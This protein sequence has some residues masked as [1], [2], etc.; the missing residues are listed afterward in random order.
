MVLAGC[1][2]ARLPSTIPPGDPS[3]PV[4]QEQ[5]VIGL[6]ASGDLAAAELIDADGE[7]PRLTLQRM[8]RAGSARELLVAPEATASAVAGDLRA[9]GRMAVPLLGAAV[10]AR[11]PEAIVAAAQAGLPLATPAAAEPG[12]RR[13]AFR[14][15]VPLSLRTAEVDGSPRAAALLLSERPLGRAGGDEIE[16]ARLPLLGAAIEPEVY[17]AGNTA[18]MLAGSVDGGDRR[19][20]LRRTVAL[21]RGSLA[22]G[23][24]ELH[25]GH[26][27]A[28]YAAGD[29]D[30]ARREFSRALQADGGYFDAL[31]NGAAIAALSDKAEEAIELLYRAARADPGRVQVLG[32]TDEDLRVLR[33]RAEVRGLLGL[34]RTPPGDLDP[35]R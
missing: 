14:G 31:Y 16:L 20:P 28:D 35:R 22:R 18:W 4:V 26:G 23:E 17:L 21:R 11:W 25:N 15:T 10:V 1:A 3:R 8:D 2:E 5:A 30:A 27:L 7:P 29:L 12:R 32:R 33:R 34:R 9:K 13:W 6:A 19:S 24:A